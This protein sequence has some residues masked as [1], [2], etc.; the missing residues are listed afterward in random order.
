M[1]ARCGR[2]FGRPPS[3]E[4]VGT[5]WNPL[6]F[7]GARCNPLERRSTSGNRPTGRYGRPAASVARA[8]VRDTTN[9]LNCDSYHVRLVVSQPP[10]A[11]ARRSSREAA[12]ASRMGD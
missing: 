6:E 5:R 8:R 11:H 7:T 12:A 10:A 4:P 2:F 9:S 1:G 3:L